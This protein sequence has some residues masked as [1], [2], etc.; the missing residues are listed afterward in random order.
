MRTGEWS[1]WQR[2]KEVA[3]VDMKDVPGVQ[4]ADIIAWAVNRENVV[5][6]G[7]KASRMAHVIRQ[8]IPA[9]HIVWDEATM[10]K[11]FKPFNPFANK[12]EE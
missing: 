9:W 12:P 2:I 6:Y 4:A 3:T 1:V 7:K 8:I 11:H 5:E 10:K